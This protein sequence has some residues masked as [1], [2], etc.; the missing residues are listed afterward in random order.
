MNMK[1]I[2]QI[3]E[4][5]SKYYNYKKRT[6]L[7]RMRTKPDAFK[8]LITCLLSLRTQDK[9]TEIASRNLFEVAHTPEEILKIPI[10]KL[11]KL[12]YSSGHYKKK[13]KNIAGCFKGNLGKI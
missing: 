13:G 4:I 2:S 6:I 8:I 5:L 1:Y 9:N 12:I 10:N 3:M 7:N 11:E